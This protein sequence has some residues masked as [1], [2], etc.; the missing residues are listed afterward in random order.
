MP[1]FVLSAIYFLLLLSINK[2]S[3]D[4]CPPPQDHLIL[5]FSTVS[6][7]VT[8]GIWIIETVIITGKIIWVHGFE[9]HMDF[10][11]AEREQG[12]C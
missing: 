3:S 5:Y 6:G 8:R 10:T 12:S 9:F 1:P 11:Q 4:L 7:L 2:I